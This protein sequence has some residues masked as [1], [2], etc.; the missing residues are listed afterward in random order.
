[1]FHNYYIIKLLVIN[2]K[3]LFI[4]FVILIF[5]AN[6][7][8]FSKIDI[9]PYHL[10]NAVEE[11]HYLRLKYYDILNEWNKEKAGFIKEIES[12]EYEINRLNKNVNDLNDKNI[13]LTD[14]IIK[15][16]DS[17][18]VDRDYLHYFIPLIKKYISLI[19]DYVDT[20]LPFDI[21]ARK[22]NILKIKN[23]IENEKNNLSDIFEDVINL[24]L[25]E[26]E[27]I[28]SVIIDKDVIEIKQQNYLVNVIKVGQLGLYFTSPDNKFTGMFVKKSNIDYNVYTDLDNSQKDNIIKTIKILE[29]SILPEI[30]F[31]PFLNN[32]NSK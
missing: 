8:V 9:S 4:F 21:R 15:L 7:S 17:L 2:L 14:E 1:M 19:E 13:L 29:N 23:M 6:I 28:S 30:V 26:L 27:N 5:A 16:K 24:Y 11:I 12:L 32:L 22:Q 3:C 18:S 31:F 20:T 10:K 25:S